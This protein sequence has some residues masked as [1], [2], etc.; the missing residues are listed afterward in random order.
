MHKGEDVRTLCAGAGVV[1]NK[2]KTHVVTLLNARIFCPHP[3]RLYPDDVHHL[4][5]TP[6]S[7]CARTRPVHPLVSRLSP[8]LRTATAAWFVGRALVWMIAGARGAWPLSMWTPQDAAHSPIWSLWVHLCLGF[9]AVAPALLNLPASTWMMSLSAEALLLAASVAV[10]ALVRR[11][12]MPQTAEVATWAWCLCPLWGA[13]GPASSWHFGVSLVLI[14]CGAAA[15]AR[16]VWGALLFLLGVGFRVDMVVAA[17]LF[18][19]LMVTSWVPARGPH[20]WAW[21]A[22]LVA[23]ASLPGSIFLAILMGGRLGVSVRTLHP[24]PLVHTL[25]SELGTWVLVPCVLGL[26]AGLLVLYA[27]QVPRFWALSALMLPWPLLFSPPQSI[28]PVL[29]LAFPLY[30]VI[31]R[32]CEEPGRQRVLLMGCALVMVGLGGFSG[33]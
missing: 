27:R 14:A 22:G 13:L 28:L 6:P 3:L 15:R 8:A 21:I 18:T 25:P 20:A 4:T 11:D 33:M 7:P 12:A 23:H 9:D 29:L 10:F 1:V 19:A 31:G 26:A 16:P 32:A 24:E 5:P 17:P 30:G 2:A